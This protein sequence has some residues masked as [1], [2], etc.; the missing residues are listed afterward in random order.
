MTSQEVDSAAAAISE[1]ARNAGDIK[2]LLDL[3]HRLFLLCSELDKSG[4][5]IETGDLMRL[6]SALENLS[7]MLRIL[8][9]AAAVRIAS[10]ERAVGNVSQH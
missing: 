6:G 3:E 7:R 10:I 1:G 4:S 9:K 5:Q 8:A 2:G